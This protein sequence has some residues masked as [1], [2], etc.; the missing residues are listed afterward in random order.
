MMISDRVQRIEPSATLKVSNLV[1]EMRNEGKEVISLSVGEPD[2][3]T[4]SVIKES[5][6][7]ALENGKTYYTSGTGIIGLRNAIK[8]KFKSENG[9]ET[10]EDNIIVTPGG[11]FSIFLA[12]QTILQEGDRAGIFDPAW[13]SYLPNIKLA[14]AEPVWLDTDEKFK[15]DLIDFK[16]KA[17]NLKMIILNSPSNPTGKVYSEELIRKIVHIAEENDIIVLSDEVYEK[18]MYEGEH[19]SPAS[20]YKNVVTVNSCSKPYAMT[21]WR[22][23]YF[24][25]PGEIVDAAKKIQSHSVSCATSFA[26]KGA[27]KALTSSRVEEKVSEM[28][29]EFEERRDLVVDGLREIKGIHCMK[30]EGAFYCFVEFDME[31]SSLEFCEKLLKERGVAV[32]PGSAFGRDREEY[33]RLSFT[34]SKEKIKEALR[35]IQSFTNDFES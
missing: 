2:F 9:I 7:K 4:P 16:N 11:K 33:F 35:K 12:C 25:G 1:K 13:V 18:L 22:I 19:Y 24:T 31:M 34:N 28:R 17:S 27:E 21:G 29:K 3:D 20:D 10:H 15:P 6:M 8:N 14:G 5:T 32:T 30:P 26:Q 23:G